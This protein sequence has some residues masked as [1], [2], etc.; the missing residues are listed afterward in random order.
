MKIK[1]D[2]NR[3]SCTS[4]LYPTLKKCDCNE[5]KQTHTPTPWEY[6][7]GSFLGVGNFFGSQENAEFIVRAVNSHYA[8]LE[9]AKISLDYLESDYI[10]SNGKDLSNGD[11][12]RIKQT[13]SQ[14]EGKQS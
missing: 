11:I 12:K 4:I 1:H 3:A 7:D 14:A 6:K 8:L 2:K 10:G 13:V 5:P 9:A